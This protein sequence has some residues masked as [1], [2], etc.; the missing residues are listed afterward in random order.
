MCKVAPHG[1]DILKLKL[2]V[3]I[4]VYLFL[5][6]PHAIQILLRLCC[7]RVLIT[8]C[9]EGGNL[10][11]NDPA[12]NQTSVSFFDTVVENIYTTVGQSKTSKP[13]TK[14]PNAATDDV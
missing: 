14:K 9:T 10:D 5:L 3:I 7:I 13:A 6:I 11:V 1:T 2:S 12:S 4:I 8:K